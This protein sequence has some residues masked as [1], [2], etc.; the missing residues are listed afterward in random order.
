MKDYQKEYQQKLCTPE[1]AVK[2]VQDGDWVDYG[3]ALATPKLL[4]QALAARAEEFNQVFMR[5]CLIYHPLA[6]LEADQR[7][8]RPVFNWNSFFMQG[9]D[10]KLIQDGYTSFIPG[11]FSMFGQYYKNENC[12]DRV[13]E[14]FIQVCPMDENG[15]FNLGPT[16]AISMEVILRAKK[17][18]VEVNKNLP[19]VYGYSDDHINIADVAAVVESDEPLDTIP[20][21]EPTDIDRKIAGL[22][23]EHIHDGDTLQL[24]IGGMPNAVGFMIADS[25]L[26]DIGIHTEMY[27]DSFKAMTKAGVVTGMKKPI[28]RGKQVFTF[29]LGS[30]DLYDWIDNNQVLMTAPAEYCNNGYL[31]STIPNFISINNAVNIDLFGQINAETAGPRQISGTG[32]QIDFVHGASLSPG[33]MSII[34]MSSTHYNKKLGKEESRILPT[35]PQGTAITDP[36]SKVQY[37]ATEYGMVNLM[38]KS[39]WQRAEALISIAHPDLRDELIQ[40]AEKMGMWRKSNQK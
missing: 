24:G 8:G 34:A 3:F 36:R 27:V 33:G 35:L 26:K 10:R 13:D 39:L 11:H 30:Q 9:Q 12:I 38:G 4:D 37:V 22:I 29:A 20:N 25:D 1:E 28:N 15:N 23:M 6:V 5:G 2:L 14:L 18:I 16:S 21:I 40:E 32:G 17:I 31:V 7:L 19:R